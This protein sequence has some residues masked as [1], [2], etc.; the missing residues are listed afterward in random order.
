MTIE[1]RL[2]STGSVTG[3]GGGGG[4]T[5]GT[6]AFTGG[7][8]GSVLFIGA[9]EVVQQDNA[10]FFWDDTNNRLGIGTSSPAAPIHS[11]ATLNYRGMGTG[12]LIRAGVSDP[13][14]ILE[15][16]ATTDAVGFHLTSS[17]L[18]TH[19]ITS[20]SFAAGTI[21]TIIDSSSR[22]GIGTATL[23][24][25]MLHVTNSPA[26][27]IGTIIQ[28]APSQTASLQEW[29]NSS[30]TKLAAVISSGSFEL[31]GAATA[32]AAP[33]T[34]K[35]N[36]SG[37]GFVVEHPT[38]AGEYTRF[39]SGGAVKG[40]EGTGSVVFEISNVGN[41]SI[42]PGGGVEVLLLST[43]TR[44]ALFVSSGAAI[45]PVVVR[46]A[47]SQSG[48]L[49]N[50]ENSSSTVL[51]SVGS[52]GEL[53][54]Y[55]TVATT[56]WGLHAIYGTGRSTAQTAATTT[57]ATYTVGASDGSFIISSNVLVTTSTT[58]NFTVTCAYTDEGNTARTLTLSF[59]SLGATLLSAIT[60]GTGAGPYEG[61]PLHIRCK[62]ATAITIATTGT[63]TAVTYNVEGTITQIS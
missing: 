7:T 36:G 13:S 55:R 8:T 57:V 26:S 56:G 21:A 35:A 11:I 1:T 43:T 3:V 9:S 20:G 47:S 53:K 40:M 18:R 45:I 33:L 49:Q 12:M 59:S 48:N 5:V 58:H 19:I 32:V 63:F 37:V 46:G 4:V 31:G 22:F 38:D 60:N 51:S 24:N 2:R 23:L 30:G 50:W 34:I 6:T 16:T 25:A 44:N 27:R 52:V 41:V 54:D 39:L 42:R 62:A 15:A 29:Q 28:G 14:I 61:V 17:S 10:N